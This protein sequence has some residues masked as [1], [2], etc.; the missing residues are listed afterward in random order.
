M[1]QI[2]PSIFLK[3]ENVPEYVHSPSVDGPQGTHAELSEKDAFPLTR[4]EVHV[5]PAHLPETS[6]K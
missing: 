4:Q 5:Y 1:Q 6:Y 3:E 2:S